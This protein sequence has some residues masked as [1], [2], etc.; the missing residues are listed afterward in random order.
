[1]RRYNKRDFHSSATKPPFLPAALRAAQTCRY[2]VYSEA[3]FEVFRPQGRHVAP[4]GVKFGTEEE[5]EGALLYVKFHPIG[6]TTRVFC[7]VP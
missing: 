5:T 1:M 4:M 2:L 6:A 7:S 3:D